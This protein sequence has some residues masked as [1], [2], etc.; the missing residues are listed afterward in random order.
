MIY[1]IQIQGD[2][3]CALFADDMKQV[4]GV[5]GEVEKIEFGDWVEVKYLICTDILSQ[6]G[7]DMYLLGSK[8]GKKYGILFGLQVDDEIVD[9]T[10]IISDMEKVNGK[11]AG[12]IT[13]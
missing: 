6:N 8:D 2:K 5:D 7:K 1:A 13:I 3:I 12:I 4:S 10:K 9:I 11:N